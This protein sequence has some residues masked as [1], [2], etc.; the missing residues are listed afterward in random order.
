VRSSS[1]SLTGLSYPVR[2]ED[3]YAHTKK[4]ADEAFGDRTKTTESESTGVVRV[5]DL[6]GDVLDMSSTCWSLRLPV[7][8]G[9]FAGPVRT[10]STTSKAG[11]LRSD[12]EKVSLAS[13]SPSPSI[14]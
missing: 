2:D 14:V 5:L 7:K 9:M 10:A 6:G 3:Q 11:M 1:L 12:G 13:A 4:K 8:R